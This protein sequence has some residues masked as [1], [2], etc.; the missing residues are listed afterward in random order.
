MIWW[1]GGSAYC[2]SFNECRSML[3]LV[4]LLSFQIFVE[5]SLVFWIDGFSGFCGLLLVGGG[6]IEKITKWYCEPNC[7]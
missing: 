6:L 5:D 2:W 4:S 3:V 7:W 1:S